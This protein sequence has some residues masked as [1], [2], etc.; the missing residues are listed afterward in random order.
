ME[1]GGKWA[2]LQKDTQSDSF[3]D[4]SVPLCIN[5]IVIL[6]CDSALLLSKMLSWGKLGRA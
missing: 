5:V 6:H 2:C 3:G 1:S 4:G